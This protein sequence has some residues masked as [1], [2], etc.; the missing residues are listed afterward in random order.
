MSELVGEEGDKVK[1]AGQTQKEREG[2][3]E[4]EEGGRDGWMNLCEVMNV[5]HR[6]AVVF[7]FTAEDSVLVYGLRAEKKGGGLMI[8][9]FS[10]ER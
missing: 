10:F 9:V 3:G 1:M 5:M 7:S 8:V 2:K 6:L 4:R